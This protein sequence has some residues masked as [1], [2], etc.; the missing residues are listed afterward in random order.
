MDSF[1]LSVAIGASPWYLKYQDG[2]DG[3]EVRSRD[4]KC[5][6]KEGERERERREEKEEE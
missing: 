4:E 3:R 6:E 1:L 5:N 2:G